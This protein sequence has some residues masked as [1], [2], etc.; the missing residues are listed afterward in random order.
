MQIHLEPLAWAQNVTED[1]NV[2]LY[3]VLV[4]FGQLYFDYGHPDIEPAVW[5]QVRKSLDMRWQKSDQ[6]VF[7]MAI[8][9]N[10]YLRDRCFNRQVTNLTPMGLSHIAKQLY[11]REGSKGNIL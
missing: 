2:K 10:P 6:D 3:H 11:M 1:V 4:T 7:I 8:V 5:E 9:L